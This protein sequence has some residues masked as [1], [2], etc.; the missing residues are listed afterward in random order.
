MLLHHSAV[1][2]LTLKPPLKANIRIKIYI[3]LYL[4]IYIPSKGALYLHLYPNLYPL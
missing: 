3:Y 1:P 2:G 4:Y